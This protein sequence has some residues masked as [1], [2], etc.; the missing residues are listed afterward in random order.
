[1][2]QLLNADLIRTRTADARGVAE[3]HV[4]DPVSAA[5]HAGSWGC[6]KASVKALVEALT[7]K[8]IMSASRDGAEF[9]IGSLIHYQNETVLVRDVDSDGDARFIAT[10][11]NTTNNMGTSY[12]EPTSEWTV[13]TPEQVDDF[14]AELGL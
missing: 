2:T 3:P 7:G 13:A 8:P 6:Q 11:L 9:V 14:L 12:I 1:M 10:D 5:F 4:I